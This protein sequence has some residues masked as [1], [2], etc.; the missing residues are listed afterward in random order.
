VDG[1][2]ESQQPHL[3]RAGVVVH[4]QVSPARLGLL[5]QLGQPPV[6]GTIDL[7][8]SVV[9]THLRTDLRAEQENLSLAG[10]GGDQDP[11]S[12]LV[13][14]GRGKQYEEPLEPLSALIETLNERFGMDLDEADRVWFEQQKTHM[15]N[16]TTVRTVAL[17]NDFEQFKIWL[18]PRIQDA[19]IDRQDANQDLFEA[20]FNKE[21]FASLMAQWL[22]ETLYGDIRNTA[23]GA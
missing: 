7:D 6:G 9:L 22:T 10:Q 1:G 8:G 5:T 11:L 21:E 15:Q 17:N 18:A 23:S 16:D 12:V 13:G 19:I 4:D 14:E 3:F 2:G 20:F